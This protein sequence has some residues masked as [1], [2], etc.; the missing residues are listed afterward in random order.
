MKM[1]LGKYQAF[2]ILETI[3]IKINAFRRESIYGTFYIEP[4]IRLE[5]DKLSEMRKSVVKP[6]KSYH[7][8][9]KS[10]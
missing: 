8:E 6:R 2:T 5:L 9:H 7:Q 4:I 3:N 1:R 10:L